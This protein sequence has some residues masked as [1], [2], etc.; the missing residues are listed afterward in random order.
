MI[1]DM[2]KR[3]NIGL[4]YWSNYLLKTVYL[5]TFYLI[6]LL[7]AIFYYL[8]NIIN[9]DQINHIWVYLVALYLGVTNRKLDTSKIYMRIFICF[10]L[11]K[12][13]HQIL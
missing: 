11:T 1:C 3:A 12:Q 4:E 10:T 5:K 7:R 13:K 9:S 2:L 6:P 8:I